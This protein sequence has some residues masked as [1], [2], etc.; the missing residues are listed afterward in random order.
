MS[1]IFA[2]VV[3]VLA[4]GA[5]QF[6]KYYFATNFLEAESR[7]AINGF[8]EWN[9]VKNRGAAW[10]MLDGHTWLLLAFTVVA[11]LVCIALLVKSGKKN[12]LLFWSITLILS[13]GLGNMIDRIFRGYVVDFIHLQFMDFPV[14]NVADC[15]IV[16]GAGLLMLNFILDFKASSKQ[17]N[18]IVLPDDIAE[19]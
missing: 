5:D 19:E 15:V 17:K 11:M 6:S 16:I 7:P 10:G 9:F 4:L 8:F 2:V 12:K 3:G 13:G 14:F 18:E 1:Y